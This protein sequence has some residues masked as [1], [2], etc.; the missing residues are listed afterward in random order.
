[1][2]TRLDRRAKR[3]LS[4]L[5]ADRHSSPMRET[6]SLA[7][8]ERTLWTGPETCVRFGI[9]DRDV[10]GDDLRA[11]AESMVVHTG[12]AHDCSGRLFTTQIH[13]HANPDGRVS[14]VHELAIDA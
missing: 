5:L 11:F 4:R 14:Y 2:K 10:A 1:M 12:R 8:T 7:V 6:E 9:V 13:T 3:L